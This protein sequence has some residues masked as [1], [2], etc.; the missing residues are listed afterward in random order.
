MMVHAMFMMSFIY[1]GEVLFDSHPL[2]VCALP[3]YLI[4]SMICLTRYMGS[5]FQV[6][7]GFPFAF[8]P[9]G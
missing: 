2:Q 7:A 6:T 9:L 5:A 3:A 4:F 8:L 1:S